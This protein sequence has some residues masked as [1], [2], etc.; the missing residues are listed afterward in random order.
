VRAELHPKPAAVIGSYDKD[1]K[2]NIMTAAWIGISNSNP[3]SIAVSM[4]P[5]TYSYG[6]LTETGFY[7]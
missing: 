1:G 2:P 5:A 3:L 4:R 7:S 6:N